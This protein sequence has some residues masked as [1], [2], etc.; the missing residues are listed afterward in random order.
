M[1]SA[2]FMWE[3]GEYDD[4]FHR[5]NDI[6]EDVARSLPGYLGVDAWQSA[7]GARRNAIYYWESLEALHAFST[8]ASHL[9][10]KR[11]YSRWY[12]GFHIVVCEVLKSYGDDR[13]EHAT[14]NQRAR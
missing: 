3:P 14:P 7:D 4:E 10:A 5:L 12:K 8:H 2:S 9:E 11:Q 6:I 1:Y 13:F